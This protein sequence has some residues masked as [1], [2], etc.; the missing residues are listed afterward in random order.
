MEKTKATRNG[1][2]AV[3][4]TLVP[5][6]YIATGMNFQ[7][8]SLRRMSSNKKETNWINSN[9]YECIEG[10][11]AHI[12]NRFG[13]TVGDVSKQGSGRSAS[14]KLLMSP[15]VFLY[16]PA[17]YSLRSSSFSFRYTVCR[18]SLLVSTESSFPRELSFVYMTTRSPSMAVESGTKKGK[19]KHTEALRGISL[20]SSRRLLPCTCIEIY[21]LP[22]CSFFYFFFFPFYSRSVEEFQEQT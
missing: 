1:T 16:V 11:A 19:C 9:R 2:I 5:F 22:F 17:I 13:I 10:K 6:F 20:A 18:L 15:I 14:I 4:I 21:W 7:W 8:Q 12:E 3:Q